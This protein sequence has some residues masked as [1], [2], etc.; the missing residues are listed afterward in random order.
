MFKITTI[1][2]A[3]LILAAGSALAQEAQKLER[4]QITGS[5]IKRV[6]SET[7]LPVTVISRDA[8]EK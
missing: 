5:S 8:I 4:I 3:V 7:A 6:E 1:S 2:S